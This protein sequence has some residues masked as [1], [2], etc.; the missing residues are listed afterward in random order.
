MLYKLVAVTDLLGE[1]KTDD[2]SVN[3]IG[4]IFEVNGGKIEY[5]KS[6]FMSCVYPGFLKSVIT[7]H[8]KGLT[9][10]NDGLI[11]TTENSI[12]FLVEKE[13]ADRYEN[14]DI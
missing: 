10:A 3:R 8:V 6:L 12:Y 14:Q 13:I 7:S 9:R 2:E 1:N 5:D 11:I 4:R